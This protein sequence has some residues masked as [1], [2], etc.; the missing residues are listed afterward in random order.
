[1]THE[2][3]L[4]AITVPCVYLHAKESIS[5][6]GTFLCAASRNQANRAA[7]YIGDNCKLVET[8]TSDH[9]IHTVHSDVYIAAVNSLQE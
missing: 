4:S 7:A 1:M 2:E 6:T 8:D 5:E 3:I 9:V